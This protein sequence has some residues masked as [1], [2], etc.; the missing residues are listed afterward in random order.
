MAQ[1]ANDII[2]WHTDIEIVVLAVSE[3][4][5]NS[6]DKIPG[7]AAVGEEVVVVA[8]PQCFRQLVANVETTVKFHLNQFPVDLFF[9]PN[10]F[11]KMMM[12]VAV[13]DH[14][15]VSEILVLT[16]FPLMKNG[17]LVPPVQSVEISAMFHLNQQVRNQFIA[18][19]ALEQVQ[20]IKIAEVEIHKLLSN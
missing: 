3:V 4:E 1:C 15:Q 8:H 14:L 7:D 13:M 9:V 5:K 6:E 16:I 18:V 2:L 19:N 10:V 17:C 11:V 12:V 20:V